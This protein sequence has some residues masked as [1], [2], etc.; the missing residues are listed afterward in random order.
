MSRTASYMT[1]CRKLYTTSP[2]LY[3]LEPWVMV[4]PAGIRKHF[5]T[6]LIHTLYV[7]VIHTD[8]SSTNCQIIS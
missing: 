8:L 4:T 7:I 3:S 2:G 6:D 5:C 1:L